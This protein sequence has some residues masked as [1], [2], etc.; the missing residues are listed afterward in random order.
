M[1]DGG[2]MLYIFMHQEA[3][4]SLYVTLTS[5]DTSLYFVRICRLWTTLPLIDINLSVD[6]IR[7]R[8]LSRISGINLLTTLTPR[9]PHT[10]RYLELCPCSWQ[11]AT[12]YFSINYTLIIRSTLPSLCFRFIV[13]TLQALCTGIPG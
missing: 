9:D 4:Y 8:E 6:T 5:N 7:N 2:H 11:C 12:D 13:I 10:M 1:H 3:S